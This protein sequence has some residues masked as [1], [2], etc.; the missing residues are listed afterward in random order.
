[1]SFFMSSARRQFLKTTA[2]TGLAISGSTLGFRLPLPEV[3]AAETVGAGS[4][5]Q[6]PDPI[7]PLVQLIEKTPRGE[8]IEKVARRVQNGTSYQE[9]LAALLL[10]GIRNVQPYP[11]VGFKFH[12]VLVVNSCHLASLAGPDEDRWL[13]I[14]WAIDH[15]KSS[16]ADEQR[17]SGWRMA[18]VDE[19]K[20]P[21][22][23][24][25]KKEFIAAMDTWDLDRA[26]RATAVLVRNTGATDVFNLFAQYAARD[27]RSIG[28][29]AI[30]LANSWRT[31][32][33]IG[34]QYAEPV[35]RSL[36]AALLNHSG[37]P[38][39]AESSLGADESW[40]SI[41]QVLSQLPANWTAGL[42]D[43]GAVT[44]LHEAFRSA[45]PVECVNSGAEALAGGAGVQSIW[46]AVFTGA[47]EL[48]MRQPGIIGLH[49][50]T[51]ANAV[52][53]LFE[54]A[55]DPRLRQKLALQACGFNAY[56]R[57]AAKGR[58]N[59]ADTLLD[60]LAESAQDTANSSV[61]EILHDISGNRQNAAHKLLAHLE[62]GGDPHAFIDAARRMVFLK[63]NDAHDYK[64]NS[65]VLE[66]FAHVSPHWRNRFLA[67]S[68]FNL[69][70]AGEPDNQLVQRIENALS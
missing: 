21:D 50:L 33:V 57:E 2:A 68:V 45:T 55:A 9:L 36:T 41:D 7:E 46:D 66:D 20:I 37:E 44:T 40:R 30:Y 43:V 22:A 60:S 62:A 11:S 12:C 34:W 14:F 58:G 35:L 61:E 28:H 27:F 4:L 42:S 39:P 26:D 1:W 56:F 67:T 18:A 48:L 3:C 23:T 16:Q 17:R 13:P 6:F 8:L 10:A 19:S 59:V 52:H 47:G 70:G 64:F 24:A 25:A 51:T 54:N 65:A 49:G 15:F 32:Q 63:G 69:N 5:V 38:N 31:L 53:Y 29:K